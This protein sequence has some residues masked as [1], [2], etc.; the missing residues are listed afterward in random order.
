MS[1]V[2]IDQDPQGEMNRQHA[3]FAPEQAARAGSPRGYYRDDPRLKSPLLAAVFSLMPG[4]GQIYIGYYAQ[5][6]INIVIIASVITILADDAGRLTPFLALFL[7]FYWLY[8]VV[9]AA[10][11]ATLYNQAIEGVAPAEYLA[12]IQ[13]PDK[14]GSLFWGALLILVGAVALSHTAYGYSLAWLDRWWPAVFVL[15]GL[16]L[17]YKSIETRWKDKPE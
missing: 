10:R 12:S 9:D 13:L 1:N 3:G 8:N 7:A 4:L 6:F 14:G 16:Y 15:I 5:G 2:R 17:I 11:R